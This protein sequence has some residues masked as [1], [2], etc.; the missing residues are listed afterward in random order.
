L[1]GYTQKVEGWITIVIL[2]IFFGGII[3]MSLGLIGE[4]VGRIFMSVNK[5]PQFTIDKIINKQ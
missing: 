2:I 4:Y 3:L 5:K 1:A